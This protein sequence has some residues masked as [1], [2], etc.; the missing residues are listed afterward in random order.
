AGL[1]KL[2]LPWSISYLSFLLLQPFLPDRL[3]GLETL[4]DGFIFPAATK[5]LRLQG[6]RKN[7]L[8]F[9][10]TVM[11]A[12]LAHALLSASG[13][14]AAALAFQHHS[15]QVAWIAC[16][17]LGCLVSGFRFY[18]LCANPELEPAGF[19]KDRAV[20]CVSSFSSRAGWG[21]AHFSAPLGRSMSGW[22]FMAQAASLARRQADLFA[23][24]F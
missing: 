20:G 22:R 5:T 13:L 6:K 21:P 9:A 8:S 19:Y 16:V 15:V 24:L 3:A 18:H 7:Y 10:P 17:V 12:T 2:Y 4:M 14:L 23:I 11:A 1:Y